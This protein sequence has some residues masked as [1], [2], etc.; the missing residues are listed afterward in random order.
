MRTPSRQARAAAASR[1]RADTATTDSSDTAYQAFARHAATTRCQRRAQEQEVFGHGPRRDDVIARRLAKL[2]IGVHWG[3]TLMVGKVATRGPLDVTALGDQMNEA[4]SNAWIQ[5]TRRRP[6]RTPTR[7]PTR[8]SAS[9]TAPETR[10]SATP[11][12]SPSPRSNDA[13]PRFCFPCERGSGR[14]RL[15]LALVPRLAGVAVL[16][17]DQC[18]EEAGGQRVVPSPRA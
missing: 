2:N 11:G 13:A 15:C 5:K 16:V 18:V 4:S 7:S 3:A 8:R 9:S 17:A 14:Q 12:T 6:P 10:R 1:E